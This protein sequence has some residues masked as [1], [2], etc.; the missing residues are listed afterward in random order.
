MSDTIKFILN[1]APHEIS[2]VA[3]TTTVLQY[4]REHLRL[5]GTKEGCA[6]GDCG[7]CTVVLG[8][9]ID[10]ETRYKSVNACILFVPVLDGKHLI[11]V[12]HLR[13][14]ESGALHP[15]Q[16]AMVDCHGSQCG[17]CTPGFVMSLYALGHNKNK[18]DDTDI[19]NAIAGNLCRCTGYRPILDAARS[20]GGFKIPENTALKK[21]QRSSGL[22]YE[23]DSIKFFAPHKAHEFSAL[24]AEYPDAHILSGGT[25]IGLWVTKHHKELPVLIYTGEIAS[26]RRVNETDDAIEIGS[27]VSYSD[28]FAHLADFDD[29]LAALLQRF[30]S[31][32]IRNS[33][34]LGGN[35]ANGS[36]IGDGAPFL[37]ALGAQ[38]VLRKAEDTR[39]IPIEDYFLAYGKQDLREG[40]FLEKI[41]VPRKPENVLFKTYKLSK[42]FDQDISAVCGAYALTITDGKITDVRIAYGGM[43][44]TPKRAEQ[45]EKFLTGKNWTEENCRTAM[46]EMSK[47]YTPL[48]DMRASAAYRMQT[49]QNLLYRFFI[50][51]TQPDTQTR[52]YDYAR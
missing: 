25:D 8:E 38:L 14:K 34:T 29:S 24:L 23:A 47:D 7:A 18:P 32:Q 11:T 40:E 22:A 45:T 10:G 41:I 36:P 31:V 37:I 44:A 2:G 49:A 46:E 52:V 30:A 39:T 51:T 15:V 28:A 6:E 48:T 20:M 27:S 5:K 50:E 21:L 35:I 26:L 4:L 19:Q 13:D 9:M 1:D 43:A 3:P 33:G 42:R 17:F 16:Q 12:E